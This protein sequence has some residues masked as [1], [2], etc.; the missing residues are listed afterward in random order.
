M[1]GI[2]VH[3]SESHASSFSVSESS[4]SKSKLTSIAPAPPGPG[5]MP[6]C[7]L[8]IRFSTTRLAMAAPSAACFQGLTLILAE[9]G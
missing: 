1:S 4:A 5:P 8:L 2:I 7:S 6:R 3:H 9:L